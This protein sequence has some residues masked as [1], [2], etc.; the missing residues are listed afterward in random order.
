[1]ASDTH[2]YT[3]T[4]SGMPDVD[5]IN[6]YC[7][8]GATLTVQGAAT[9]IANLHTDQAGLI[10]LIRCLHNLGCTL[11]SISTEPGPAP[12]AGKVSVMANTGPR[13]GFR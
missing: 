1:M 4:I 5:F 9:T 13:A 3:L 7:P 6:H 8:A 11:L 12:A 2:C 10:G